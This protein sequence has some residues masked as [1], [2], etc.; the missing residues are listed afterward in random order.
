MSTA[1]TLVARAKALNVEL[2]L[3]P[4]GGAKA[5]NVPKDFLLELRAHKAEILA[6]LRAQAAKAANTPATRRNIAWQA[7]NR[8][9]PD[10]AIRAKVWRQAEQEERNWGFLVR[11]HGYPAGWFLFAHVDNHLR[12]HRGKGIA[13][14]SVDG[15]VVA[16]WI[17][18]A[19]IADTLTP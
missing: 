6:L 11:E 2:V 1:D 13:T 17:V 4:D 18:D 9:E 15:D 3:T 14:E 5:R 7:L 19:P 10:A 12:L 16:W 8:L